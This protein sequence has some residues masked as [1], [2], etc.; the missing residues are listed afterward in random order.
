MRYL[1]RR[2]M[3]ANATWIRLMGFRVI[4]RKTA[5]GAA[6]GA[7]GTSRSAG[8]ADRRTEIHHRLVDHV[9]L[10]F[11]NDV[12]G[13]LPQGSLRAA[14]LET[15]ADAEVSGEQPRHIRIDDRR[16]FLEREAQHRSRRVA[17]DTIHRP[18]AVV[19]VRD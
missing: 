11:R 13:Q 2:S 8:R 19:P 15:A 16:V 7:R 17:A 12:L 9:P 5:A 6:E 18:E 1:P 3:S 4:E 14:P 10:A